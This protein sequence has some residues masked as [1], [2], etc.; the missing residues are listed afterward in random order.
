MEKDTE[1]DKLIESL[2]EEIQLLKNTIDNL[3]FTV[4]YL[5]ESNKL[6]SNDMMELDRELDNKSKSLSEFL[7]KHGL[8]FEDI[9]EYET[10]KKM[11]DTE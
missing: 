9:I 5:R 11:N 7:I 10:E 8:S 3:N 6:M 2:H 1:K 4:N